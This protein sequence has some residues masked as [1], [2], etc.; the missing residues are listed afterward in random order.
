MSRVSAVQ[1]PLVLKELLREA[2]AAGPRASARAS[3]RRAQDSR[4]EPKEEAAVE[5]EAR[6][7]R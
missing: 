6:A 4:A 5:S 2:P 3:F 1:E 7:R